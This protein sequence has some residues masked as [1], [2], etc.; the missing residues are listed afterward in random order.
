MYDMYDI[1]DAV[2]LWYGN[3]LMQRMFGLD[4]ELLLVPHILD[5]LLDDYSK[6][7]WESNTKVVDILKF[8]T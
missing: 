6:A 4:R 1:Y 8:N 2:I 5:S 3:P 7:L